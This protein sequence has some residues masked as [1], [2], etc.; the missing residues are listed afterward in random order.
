[1][2][3]NN[4]PEE[5]R[6]LNQWVV[7]RLETTDDGKETKLPYNPQTGRMASVT[8]PS[9]WVTFDIACQAVAQGWFSGI[10]FVFTRNDP[11]CGIDLDATDDTEIFARQQKIYEMMASY[12]EFS[13]SGKGIHIIVKGA[14]PSGRKRAKIEIYSHERYFTFTGNIRIQAPIE[15]RNE[16]V[17][18]L[19]E[20]MGP[21]A[22]D[23]YFAGKI[24]PDMFT[25][26]LLVKIRSAQNAELFNKLFSGDWSGYSSQSE[27]DQALMN[28]IAFHTQNR[29]QIIEIFRMS[30]LGQRDKAKRLSYLTYTI[31]KA[32]DQQ[33]P[34]IDMD[35]IINEA[36]AALEAKRVASIP[37]Q[38]FNPASNTHAAP[39]EPRLVEP[40]QFAGS[41]S[42]ARSYDDFDLDYWRR[43]DP[44]GLMK[45]ARDFIYQ[46]AP[47]QV[48]EIA[49]AA[50][51]GLMAGMTGRAYNVS[52][53]GLNQY[54]M[55]LA[56]TGRG[57]EAMSSGINK[58]VTAA[59]NGNEYPAIWD[60]LGPSDMASGS[61]LLKHLAERI[62]PSFVSLTGEVGLRM[63]QLSAPNA[64]MA[65]VTLRRVLLDLY[66][67]SGAGSVIRPTVYSD[68]KNNIEMIQ[69]PAFTWLGESTPEEFYKALTEDQVRSGLLPRFT[70]IE[71][72]GPRLGMNEGHDRHR[73][74][75]ALIRA[76]QELAV[77]AL[78]SMQSGKVIDVGMTGQAV[79]YAQTV[80]HY[81]DT[82]I[83]AA[84]SDAL[85][86]LWNRHHLKVLKTAAL[87]AVSLNAYHP[88]IDHHMIE[89]ANALIME[90]TLKVIGQ[91]ESGATGMN[92]T[93]DTKQ[94]RDLHHIIMKYVRGEY[95]LGVTELAQRDQFVISRSLL[96]NKAYGLVSYKESKPNAAMT[97]NKVLKDM[98]AFGW[99]EQ[100]NKAQTQ[101]MFK[102]NA[103]LFV[104]KDALINL[105]I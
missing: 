11:Y 59:V 2:T 64:N 65:D 29:S 63:Q 1:M 84:T 87:L 83:N 12:N 51:I 90:G 48:P 97:L 82:K 5:L 39:V 38:A 45:L 13:P 66:T 93:H 34:P 92:A 16:L 4:I 98:V 9:S 104:I 50:S 18:R 62:T 31:D 74:Q 73:P 95:R 24:S 77:T 35:N 22:T 99:L 58:I 57:K 55:M 6:I 46:Q 72:D 42:A 32:F 30:G 91:F 21:A 36:N 44:P 100:L 70:I 81:A 25:D 85:A 33:L 47:R 96:A 23:Q 79:Q 102:T 69:S 76:V 61:G 56:G 40:D 53:T 60:F 20:E 67:K 28:I 27:A 86:Q 89:W 41:N 68:K 54:L 26:E 7:W 43:N 3:F 19:W 101:E 15:E 10:G 49:M 17:N 88:V 105:N 103:D 75:P 80:N 52:G 94:I 37:V 78:T 14:V 71:Y 8:D